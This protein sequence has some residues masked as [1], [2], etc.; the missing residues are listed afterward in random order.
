MKNFAFALLLGL[1]C[2]LAVAS[3]PAP[4]IN[5]PGI[6]GTVATEHF[7]GKV[8]YV[9]FWASWCKPCKQSF[10]W[11]NDLQARYRKV[12]F[13]VVAINLDQESADARDFL[14]KIPAQFTVAFDPSGKTAEQFHVQGM[15]SSY[16]IDRQGNIRSTHIGFRDD[17]RARLE[18]AVSKLLQEK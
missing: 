14:Q 15:P 2:N 9:D 12:G 8:V 6:H 5:L 18:Q 13:E 3:T 17:D 10:P 16:L 7:K 1:S 4:A 11:L